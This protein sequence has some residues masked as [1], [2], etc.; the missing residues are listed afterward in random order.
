MVGDKIVGE[1]K[2]RVADKTL[3]ALMDKASSTTSL[4]LQNA[5]WTRADKYV[6][7]TLAAVV[8]LW[9]SKSLWITGSKIVA[10]DFT[11]MSGANWANIY[12]KK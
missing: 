8:P 9:Q 10:Q 5:A 2:S 6:I 1:N 12:V 4:K 7:Q 3:D 11:S